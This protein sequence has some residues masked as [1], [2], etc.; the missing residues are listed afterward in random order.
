MGT[1]EAMGRGKSCS[2]LIFWSQSVR[3]SS[4]CFRRARFALNHAYSEQRAT[5]GP[6]DKMGG[7]EMRQT[8]L[9][10]S[11]ASIALLFEQPQLPFLLGPLKEPRPV[12]L[13]DPVLATEIDLLA[14][15]RLA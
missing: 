10:L 13:S 15:W 3:S 9:Y 4:A 8:H 5:L 2:L 1:A 6:A 12:L 11:G 14:T 7:E